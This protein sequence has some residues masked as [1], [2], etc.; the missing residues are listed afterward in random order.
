MLLKA[1]LLTD[2]TAMVVC[3]WM[4]LYLFVRGFPSKITLR[5]TI[6]LLAL[7]AFYFS[8]YINLFEQIPGTAAWRAVFLITG[9]CI[10]YDITIHLVPKEARKR[11][12]PWTIAVYALGASAIILLL[13]T[14]NSFIGE[15]DNILY[16]ARMGVGLPYILYM[17]FQMTTLVGIHFNLLAHGRL[18]STPAGKYFAVASLFAAAGVGY[19]V[20]ALAL[21]PPMPRLIQDLAIFC[22]VFTL[23]I[24]V[25][26][27]QSLIERRTTLQDFPVT[28]LTVLVLTAAYILIAM[29]LGLPLRWM[30]PLAAFVV[31]THAIHDFVRELLER[32]RIR[33]ESTFRKQLRRLANEKTEDTLRLRL[34]KGLD[35]LCKT[36]DASGGFIAVKRQDHFIVLASSDPAGVEKRFPAEAFIYED[37]SSMHNMYLP[38]IRYFAPAFEGQTQIA[39]LGIRKPNMHNDYSS[40]DLDLLAEVADRI[41][42]IVSLSSIQPQLSQI[43]SLSEMNE[44]E[45]IVAA[46]NMLG[47]IETNPDQEFIKVVEESLRQLSDYIL[48][49]KSPLADKLGVQGGSHIERGRELQRLLTKAIELLQPAEKRPGEPLPRVWYNY[50]VLHDAY[51]EG[52]PNREIMARLYISEGTF[53]RTRRNAIRGLARLLM[54]KYPVIT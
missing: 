27:Y 21:A 10:W 34:K 22:G 44:N 30:A 42:T 33:H 43:I 46:S 18:A 25:A 51:V 19:A 29:R 49:G 39:V 3:L 52:V 11:L 50:V 48:L 23:G 45:A 31:I 14:A 24:S 16:V 54:E 5:G 6:L 36:L 20:L 12:L 1:T 2:L 32:L 38:E 37:V 17:L 47:T 41:G 7:T 4:A 53:N 8:A 40:G 26:R 9:L 28:C 13:G 35:L 15:R